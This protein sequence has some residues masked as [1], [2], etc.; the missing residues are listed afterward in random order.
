VSEARGRRR[1]PRVP[2]RLIFKI[3]IRKLLAVVIAHINDV[4]A[5]NINFSGSSSADPAMVS[6]SIS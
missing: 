6:V 3:N 1:L 5:A 4:D 2:P